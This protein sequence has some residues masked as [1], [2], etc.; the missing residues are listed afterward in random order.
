[1]SQLLIMED[2]REVASWY[3]RLLADRGHKVTL[4]RTGR[5]VSQNL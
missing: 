2:D 5:K 3:N 4:A 1:M